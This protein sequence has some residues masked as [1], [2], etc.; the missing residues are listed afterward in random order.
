MLGRLNL[1]E[2]VGD[3]VGQIEGGFGDE[4]G[5]GTEAAKKIG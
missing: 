2:G 5:R 1:S 4:G 3:S